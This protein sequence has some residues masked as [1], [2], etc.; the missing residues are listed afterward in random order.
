MYSKNF[1]VSE[2]YRQSGGDGTPIKIDNLAPDSLSERKAL[3]LASI[4]QL[5]PKKHA[6]TDTSKRKDKVTFV[7]NGDKDPITGADKLTKELVPPARAPL[8]I[9]R[10][11]IRQ[12]AS[13]AR[14]NGVKLKP[15]DEKSD[16]FAWVYRVW[17]ENKTDYYLRELMERYLAETQVAV[18]FYSDKTEAAR[19]KDLK[20]MKLPFKIFS[21]LKGD[22]MLPYYDPETGRLTGLLRE[23]EVDGKTRYDLYLQPDTENGGTNAVLRR[24]TEED[25][26]K[27]EDTVLPYSK[28]PLVYWDR[29]LPECD[30]VD[31]LIGE[32]EGGF[33]DFLTQ[34]GYS[35]DPILFG[36][37]RTLNLPAKGSAGK[38]IEGSED[39]DLK[40]VTPE[41]ATESRDLQFKLLQKFIFSLNRAVILDLDTM[42]ELGDVSGAAL[43]KYL[44][45]AYM[46]ATDHQTGY[47]GLG[48]QRMVNVML[49]I[50]KDLHNVAD[51]DETTVDIEFTKFRIDD[52]RETVEVLTLANGNKPLIDHLGS[53]AAAGIADDPAVAYER[54]EEEAEKALERQQAQ[55]SQQDPEAASAQRAAAA[56]GNGDPVLEKKPKKTK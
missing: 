39:S 47:W 22:Y 33:N 25:L 4:K 8:P 40:F 1:H 5:D 56:G 51:T 31:E 41:N 20:R 6:V 21:P 35:A 17:Y 9:Q 44:I 10:Y 48:V 43:D 26:T 24:F 46:E 19:K 30:D 23:Y 36:K 42:K 13:F 12:K 37:G 7:P 54:M 45:D 55:A 52:M 29:D 28:L 3:V 27:F 53:V 34:M 2:L 15:S 18:V 16:V 11:I 14:G 49:D 38:F 50:A 32:L